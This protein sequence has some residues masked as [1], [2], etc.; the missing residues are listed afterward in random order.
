MTTSDQIFS[1]DYWREIELTTLSQPRD[2]T[3]CGDIDPQAE[4]DP[5]STGNRGLSRSFLIRS[6]LQLTATLFAIFVSRHLRSLINFSTEE[7][8]LT[9]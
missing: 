1:S 4:Q 6:K 8:L 3:Q 9:L 2:N 5:E 7:P